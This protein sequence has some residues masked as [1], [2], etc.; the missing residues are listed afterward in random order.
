MQSTPDF[1]A[2]TR[3][4]NLKHLQQ[5]RSDILVVGGGITGAGIA[6]DAAMRGYA[7]ALID[8][9]DFASGTSSKSSKLVHGGI[10]YLE[11]F[12][13]G[14]VF[15]ASRERR[16]LLQIAPHLVQPLPFVFPVYR[17][18]RWAPWIIDAGLWM[19]DALALFRN[20]GRHHML[21]R[22][23][24][25]DQTRGIDTH[26]ILGGAF[27]Y[28][29]QVDDAR[30]TL[31]TLRAAHKHHARIAN[32]VQVNALLKERGRVVGV[33]AHDVLS[34]EKLDL[35]ARVVVNATGPWTDALAQMDDP[36]A[37][38]RLRPTKGAHII[39][40]RARIGTENAATFPSFV[41]Q[42]V[43]FL[44]PWNNFTIIGTTESDYDGDYD[45]VH[46]TARDVEYMLAATNHA[47]PLAK[48]TKP[49]I[50][51]AYAGLRPLLHVSG[52]DA[53]STSREHSIWVSESGLV[54]ITGG[55]LT[56]Y[57]AMAEQLVDRVVKKLRDEHDLAP[58]QKC[59]TALYPLVE[60]NG[61]GDSIL[62]PDVRAHWHRAYGADAARIAEHARQDARAARRIMEGLPYLWA[63][64]DYAVETEMAVT[65]DDFLA[66]RAH[67]LWEARDNG[68]SAAAPVAARMAELLDWDKPRVERELRAYQEQVSLARKF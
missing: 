7:V 60:S 21:S 37:P 45:R 31:E 25:A 62:E 36:R 64:V 24:V 30:L 57:R 51:S 35:R 68:V 22:A 5:N 44:V 39:V 12:Q 65:L 67:I 13:F 11:Q 47:F 3:M 41:D 15:E 46:A 19:Y 2:Q 38:T 28:D 33:S 18:G 8:K 48:L 14:L 50:I 26:N 42:R 56:T 58:K 55:K 10:R 52:K 49:D 23:A 1:S 20:Y 40:P 54:T 29:A 34:G 66:R 4:D 9:G 61:A 43:M 6:R 53:H 63:E 17:D 32:Y 59:A 16:T 27:Y